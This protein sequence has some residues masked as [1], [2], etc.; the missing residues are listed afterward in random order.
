VLGTLDAI[1]LPPRQFTDAERN[2]PRSTKVT[3]RIPNLR[4]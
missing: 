3:A 4:V 1:A 2:L